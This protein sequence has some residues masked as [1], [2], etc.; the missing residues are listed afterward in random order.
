[1]IKLNYVNIKW[2]Y[3]ELVKRKSRLVADDDAVCLL[4][5]LSD[6]SYHYTRRFSMLA[7]FLI[8]HF[9]CRYTVGVRQDA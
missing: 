3:Y 4:V 7:P 6:C 2:L 5:E 9:L 1:M 8:D